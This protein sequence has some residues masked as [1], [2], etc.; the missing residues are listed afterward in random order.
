MILKFSAKKV[1]NRPIFGQKTVFWPKTGQKRY[2][3]PKIGQFFK[4]YGENLGIY[5]KTLESL[6][7]QFSGQLKHFLGLKWPK[8]V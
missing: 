8:I 2:F 6:Y 1:K 5:E 3:G 4:F 7:Y